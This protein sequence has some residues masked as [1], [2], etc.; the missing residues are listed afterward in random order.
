MDPS[1]EIT[2]WM[3]ESLVNNTA[4]T[5]I[6]GMTLSDVRLVKLLESRDIEVPEELQIREE[7]EAWA[8]TFARRLPFRIQLDDDSLT[9]AIRADQFRRGEPPDDEI[10]RQKIEISATYKMEIGD[11]GIRMTRQGEVNVELLDLNRRLRVDEIGFKTFMRRTFS[12]MFRE[13]FVSQGITLPERLEQRLGQI[14]LRRLAA[15]NGWA[16]AGWDRSSNESGQVAAK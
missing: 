13:Q 2:V 8:I 3:H 16:T 11:R 7:N 14:R 6:G 10:L 5:M 12:A 1:N 15:S 9:M 4:E